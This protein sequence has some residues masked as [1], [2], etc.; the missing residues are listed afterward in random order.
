VEGGA[1]NYVRVGKAV[2]TA[3]IAEDTIRDLHAKMGNW[4]SPMVFCHKGSCHGRRSEARDDRTEPLH[5]P[6]RAQ[7][8]PLSIISIFSLRAR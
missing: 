4:P 8:G 2:A 3:G 5:L 1:D 7:C 6:V